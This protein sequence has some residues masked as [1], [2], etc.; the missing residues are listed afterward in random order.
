MWKCEW[1]TYAATRRALIE[2][3]SSPSSEK[4]FRFPFA[5]TLAR[6]EPPVSPATSTPCSSYS[7]PDLISPQF[8]DLRPP[9]VRNRELIPVVTTRSIKTEWRVRVAD[10][11]HLSLVNVAYL[12]WRRR[13][14]RNNGARRWLQERLT[15]GHES[16]I[17]FQSRNNSIWNQ[18]EMNSF[19]W[20]QW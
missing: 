18:W 10:I 6:L 1:S 14:P 20:K 8:L 9:G 16:M 11:K 19:N 2:S 12:L 5:L 15:R 3:I 17:I 4:N 7:V 13:V